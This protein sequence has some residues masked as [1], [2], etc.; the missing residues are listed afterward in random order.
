MSSILPDV[1]LNA[2]MLHQALLALKGELK[3]FFFFF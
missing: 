2:P 3:S 1:S